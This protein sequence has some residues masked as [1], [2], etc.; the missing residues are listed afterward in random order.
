MTGIGNR[1]P[2]TAEVREHAGGTGRDR[3]F[4]GFRFRTSRGSVGRQ[5]FVVGEAADAEDAVAIAM[6]RASLPRSRR[7]REDDAEMDGVEVRRLRWN[8]LGWVYLT[9]SRA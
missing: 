3:W 8:P 4:V 1:H 7:A 6:A 2:M 5:F 9:R